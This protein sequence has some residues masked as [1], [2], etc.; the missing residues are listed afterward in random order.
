MRR[1]P[2]WLLSLSPPGWFDAGEIVLAVSL[3]MVVA[4]LLR[5]RGALRRA[6]AAGEARFRNLTEA[7]P[8]GVVVHRQGRMLFING[9]GRATLG[10]DDG[11]TPP[12]PLPEGLVVSPAARSTGEPVH[13][14]LANGAEVDLQAITIDSEFDGRP[15]QLTFIR[16]V[17]AEQAARRE[18]AENRARLETALE[19]AR[20]GIWEL[21][22]ATGRLTGSPLFGAIVAPGRT[23][24]A[25]LGGWRDLIHPADRVRLEAAISDHQRNATAGYECEMRI[26]RADGSEAWLLEHGRVVTRDEAGRARRLAGTVR[27]ISARKRAEQRLDVRGRLAATFLAARGDELRSAIG[28]LLRER[29]EAPC[30]CVGMF[31]ANG[32]LRLACHC[33]SDDGA[34]A[35]HM[36]LP[37]D[38]VPD[39]LQRVLAAAD[40]LALAETG[41]G[42]P[43]APLLGARLVSGGR[44]LGLVAVGGRSTG[45]HRADAETLA[46]IAADLAPLVHSL[47][48]TEAKDAQLAQAQKMEALGVLAGGIAHDFNNIL[49]AILGF[50]AL[51]RQDAGDPER[52]AADLD[53]VQRATV[54]GRDLV[55]RILQFSRPGEPEAPPLDP[56]PL[57]EDLVL[58]LTGTL[59]SRIVIESRVATDCGRVRAAPQMLRQALENLTT[60]AV[61]AMEAG[62]GR[63]TVSARPWTVPTDDRR[64]PPEWCG[65]EVVEFAVTDTGP[66]IPEAHRA[67]LF[68]PF[69]TT[70][71]V[72]QGSGLGLSVVHGL[73]TGLGGH[74]AIESP[75]SGGTVA[76]IYLPR[77]RVPGH[78]F[79]SDEPP[80]FPAAAAGALRGRILFVDDD[81]EIC[82]LAA[83]LLGRAGFQV[84]TA[85]DG[86][87]A[88]ERI[89]AGPDDFDIVVTDQY[90]PGLT[91][92]E[93]ALRV[94]ALRPE[95][96]VILVSG[97]DEPADPSVAGGLVFREVVTKPFFGQSLCLAV[98][99]ALKTAPAG[100]S[101]GPVPLDSDG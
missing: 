1:F 3:V 97:L 79:V 89:T 84:E 32:R 12:A 36:L 28:A 48:E 31:D 90:M 68:D 26:R 46:G 21:D 9:S 101:A 75:T 94:A 29:I 60:N 2:D 10:L 76:A 51:A 49:Q 40:P 91:G 88:C 82:D 37:P 54:R 13:L 58:K 72:G 38:R 24:P 34:G 86:L 42:M 59:P 19:A 5:Y 41:I 93:L 57:T 8:F 66:G 44:V 74:V 30:S 15:V 47:V 98:H 61:Q 6:Q 23:P 62:G 92:R 99:R 52:L 55:Q 17:T 7:A 53:R 27:D 67:R 71:E 73:V 11:F 64:F 87:A 16:D 50:S 4:G 65:R 69:F 39:A 63:L 70:R 80:A 14:R 22:P 20:D 85:A 33:C 95:L 100:R 81:P 35:D 43:H 25:D 18:L 78:T 45:Y 56:V 96:P 77:V 83:V